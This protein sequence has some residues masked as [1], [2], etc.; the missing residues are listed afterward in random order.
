MEK[1]KLFEKRAM[2][3]ALEHISKLEDF[4]DEALKHL[5]S[6][7]IMANTSIT[8]RLLYEYDLNKNK[9]NI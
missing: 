7:I 2:E 5:A 1:Y 8:T 9:G 3:V 6:A 4:P